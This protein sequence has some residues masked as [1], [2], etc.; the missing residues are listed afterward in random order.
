MGSCPHLLMISRVSGASAT[1]KAYKPA[2][3]KGLRIARKVTTGGI[4]I[5]LQRKC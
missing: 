4:I 5:L 2:F 3:Q 1:C